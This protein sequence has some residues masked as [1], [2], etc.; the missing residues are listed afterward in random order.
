MTPFQ[1]HDC[2]FKSYLTLLLN[3]CLAENSYKNLFAPYR[4][5]FL[6]I[7]VVILSLGDRL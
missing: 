4:F 7:S 1:N 5:S 6:E 2:G 3:H